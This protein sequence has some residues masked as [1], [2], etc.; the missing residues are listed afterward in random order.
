MGSLPSVRG[1]RTTALMFIAAAIAAGCGGGGGNP[2]APSNI[3][4]LLRDGDTLPGGFQVN[5]IE[6]ANMAADRSVALIA[7]EPGS[8]AL[9]GVFV[10]SAGG[11]IS[12]L[13]TPDNPPDGLALTTVRNLDMSAT[14]EVTFEVGDQLDSD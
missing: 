12:T 1:R 13:M 10:I 5:T 3:Q 7:S 14:G 6:S 8:P 2:P 9:N 4:V 11:N